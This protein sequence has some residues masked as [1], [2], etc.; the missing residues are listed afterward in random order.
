M[1]IAVL[2]FFI[3]K[4]V[5]AVTENLVIQFAAGAILLAGFMWFISRVE[6]KEFAKLPV[7]GKYFNR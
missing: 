2:L 1:V 4:G 5:I 7:I 6:K 3:H